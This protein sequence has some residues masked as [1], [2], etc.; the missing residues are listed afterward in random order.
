[1]RKWLSLQLHWLAV[2][3]Y[4]S[5]HAEI[6]VVQDEWGI[7]RCRFELKADEMHGVAQTFSQLPM[8]WQYLVEGNTHD[9]NR[10][11]QNP[12]RY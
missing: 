7:T 11:D 6:V 2:R 9:F 8:G 4:S 5:E 1:M 12:Y 10:S 3:V